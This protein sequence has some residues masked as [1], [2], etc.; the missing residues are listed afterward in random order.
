MSLPPGT[1]ARLIFDEIYSALDRGKFTDAIRLCQ[2]SEVAKLSLAQALLSYCFATTRQTDKA[3]EMARSVMGTNPSDEPVFNALGC[4]LKLCRAD[5]EFA[6][7]YENVTKQPTG[8]TEYNLFELFFCYGRMNDSKKMQQV[9]QRIYKITDNARYLFWSVSCMLLQKDLPSAMLVVAEKMLKKVFFDIHPKQAPGAEELHLYL[10]T[11]IKQGKLEEAVAA[12]KTL[13]SRDQNAKITDDDHFKENVNLVALQ[14]LQVSSLLVDIYCKLGDFQ[15]VMTVLREING[16]FPDQWNTYELQNYLVLLSLGIDYKTNNLNAVSDL[17]CFQQESLL[18]VLWKNVPTVV[19]KKQI[20]DQHLSYLQVQKENNARLRGPYLAELYFITACVSSA[21]LRSIL[22]E[23]NA[24]VSPWQHLSQ[25]LTQYI[26]KFESKYC[27]FTDIK[28]ILFRLQDFEADSRILED[29]Q[30]FVEGK[31][32]LKLADVITSLSSRIV[33]EESTSIPTT[34]DKAQEDGSEDE[35]DV[36]VL[37]EKEPETKSKKK[38]GKKKKAGNSN[39]IM[40]GTESSNATSL[41]VKKIDKERIQSLVS[42]EEGAV[43]DMCIY[44]QLENIRSYCNQLV[45]NPS[46]TIRNEAFAI[47]QK[48]FLL[49]HSLFK[50]GIGGEI[51]IVQPGDDLLLLNSS[52]F[53]KQ[54]TV[55]SAS[56]SSKVFSLLLEWCSLLNFA[57]QASAYSYS[58]KID[59]LEVCRLIGQA[60]LALATFVDLGV[61]N[62]QVNFLYFIQIFHLAIKC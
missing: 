4:T 27:C 59:L 22:V 29:I 52:L 32:S 18:N 24:A 36:K 10:I 57:V 9:A 37:G 15:E 17:V 56:S 25:L 30:Q 1:S 13:T 44:C 51:R 43:I 26:S 48:L 41:E 12:I 20:V 8:A 61:K 16:D 14:K 62:I 34:V 3:L 5:A 31:L 23:I 55:E 6:T 21:E 60:Q 40:V 49:S 58:L 42:K 2:R 11:V 47:R 33:I 54:Y 45:S 38:R 7:L 53:R 28:T 35:K 46:E 19:D 50:N 39:S